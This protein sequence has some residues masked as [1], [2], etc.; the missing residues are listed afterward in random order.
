[1]SSLIDSGF[2]NL[3]TAQSERVYSWVGAFNMARVVASSTR[4]P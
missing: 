1:M 2:C 4:L 3:R